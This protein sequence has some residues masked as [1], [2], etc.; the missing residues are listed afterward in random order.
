MLLVTHLR[1]LGRAKITDA[2]VV[3][4]LTSHLPA[5]ADLTI[6]AWKQMEGNDGVGPWVD[7]VK[8]SW[9]LPGPL[10]S[11][12]CLLASVLHVLPCRAVILTET[13]ASTT[14]L[15]LCGHLRKCL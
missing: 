1:L 15:C 7:S 14:G 3:G 8:L 9:H 12:S 6:P 13:A 10:I 2:D 11:I 5:A 4:L